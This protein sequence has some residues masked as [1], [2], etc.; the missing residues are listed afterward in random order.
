VAARAGEHVAELDAKA[1]GSAVPTVDQ[2]RTF[3]K[4]NT[5]PSV[6]ALH[7]VVPLKP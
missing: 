1:L 4:A 6:I 3:A 2:L 7:P 5:V